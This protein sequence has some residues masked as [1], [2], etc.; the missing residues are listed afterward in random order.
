MT[1]TALALAADVPQGQLSGW[2]NGIGLA[3]WAALEK[4][5]KALSVTPA[6]LYSDDIL[7]ALRA[8]AEIA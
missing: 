7:R 5:A 8:N 2:E 4:I 3:P 6:D 1:Q